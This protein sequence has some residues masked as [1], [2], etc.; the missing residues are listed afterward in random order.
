MVRCP[1]CRQQLWNLI[2]LCRNR[3]LFCLPEHVSNCPHCGL[4]FNSR[5]N[6]DGLVEILSTYED[7]IGSHAVLDVPDTGGTERHELTLR[8]KA[9]ESLRQIIRLDPFGKRV[10]GTC[11][12]FFVPTGNGPRS[13]LTVRVEKDEQVET[14]QIPAPP[15]LTGLLEWLHGLKD[16][17]QFV[18]LRHDRARP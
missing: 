13:R 4:D 12:Y 15:A 1:G 9:S 7:E 14:V 2:T 10:Q 6:H 18:A 17:N 16:C 11:R 8:G 3:R 5:G